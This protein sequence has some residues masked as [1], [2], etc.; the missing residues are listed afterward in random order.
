ILATLW[1]VA[2]M[3]VAHVWMDYAWLT[4][5]ASLSRK[6]FSILGSRGYRIV[7]GSLGLLLIYFGI[8]FISSALA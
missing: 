8:N 7:I 1:G 2:I 6:G 4:F 5:I 3:Y